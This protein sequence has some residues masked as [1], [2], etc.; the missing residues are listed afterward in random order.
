MAIS[1]TLVGKLGGVEVNVVPHSWSSGNSTWQTIRTISVPAGERWLIAMAG[2]GTGTAELSIVGQ[3][4]VL[5]TGTQRVGVTTV[6]TGPA[7]VTIQARRNTTFGT[8]TFSGSSYTV[9]LS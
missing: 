7:T 5:S 1:S 6:E 8:A 3:Y 4:G 9:K 2:T